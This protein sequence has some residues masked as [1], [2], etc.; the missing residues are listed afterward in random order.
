MGVNVGLIREN[1]PAV[2]IH[3]L[4]LVVFLHGSNWASCAA[5]LT[6]TAR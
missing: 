1:H 3:V 6:D 2:G 5:S 4:L